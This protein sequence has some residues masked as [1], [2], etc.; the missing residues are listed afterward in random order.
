MLI[1]NKSSRGWFIAG[2]IIAPLETVDIDISEADI[3]GNPELEIVKADT[4]AKI[5]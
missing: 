1:K 5:K 4:P 2:K 3:A